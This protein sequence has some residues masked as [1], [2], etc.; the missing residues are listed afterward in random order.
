MS[1]LFTGDSKASVVNLGTIES[2]VGD[3]ILL[4][5][6]I[7]NDGVINA[8]NGVVAM[9][10]GVEIL[11][12]PEGDQRIF[13][14]AGSVDV[15]KEQGS[16]IENSGEINSLQAEL[17]S[18][19]T[20]YQYAIKTSGKINALGSL[21]KEG[22]I[23]LIAE[24]S[25]VEVTGELVAK[26]SDQTGGDIRLQGESL[27]LEEGASIDV[28]GDFGGGE[29]RIGGNYQ[30]EDP[31]QFPHAKT[32]FHAEGVHIDADAKVNGDGGL[33]VLWSQEGTGFWEVLMP[34]EALKAAMVEAWR[35]PHM[36]FLDRMGSSI[37]EHRMG[38]RGIFFG[39]RWM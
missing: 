6:T 39:I 37:L 11:L 21:K 29:V 34:K 5:R 33:V 1:L 32:I 27:I 8:P 28:S 23:H 15:E 2:S 16:S 13:I 22:R 4:A 3:V 7:Q 36:D 18:D 31:E 38:K 12:H 14:Q 10:V 9:G 25:F 17:R 19:G 20:A 24:Q 26:N 30:G 35:F